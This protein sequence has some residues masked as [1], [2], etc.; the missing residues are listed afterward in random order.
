M[1]FLFLH[2]MASQQCCTE[3]LRGFFF[4]HFMQ[5]HY[6]WGADIVLF[7]WPLVTFLFS[8]H[9]ITLQQQQRTTGRK[10]QTACLIFQ[11]HILQ[12]DLNKYHMICSSNTMQC[13]S[14][15]DKKRGILLHLVSFA[16]TKISPYPIYCEFVVVFLSRRIYHFYNL[17]DLSWDDQP[18]WDP[19]G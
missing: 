6:F 16:W 17:S 8:K 11:I 10:K 19:P 5:L 13:L 3:V 7:I 9:Y 12:D 15:I 4:L 18:G 2:V 14:H 1:W